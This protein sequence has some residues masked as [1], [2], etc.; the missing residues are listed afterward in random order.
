MNAIRY[1]NLFYILIFMILTTFGCAE[2]N[3]ITD[4]NKIIEQ[5]EPKEVVADVVSVEVTGEN[6]EY[7]FII[8]I[9]SPDLGCDQYAD[10]WEVLSEDGR[11]IYRRVL[12]HSHVNE[13][14]FVRSG[15]P[16]AITRDT[17]VIIRAHMNTTGYGGK[18][19]KGSISG[20]F[21]KI[22]LDPGFASE[23]EDQD[24]QPGDCAF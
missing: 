11:L 5:D 12:A 24:P 19:M 10:W 4:E 22:N 9:K 1:K 15:G 2:S 23:V 14:P 13:Q 16:V 17:I 7:Q 6:S 18:S 3:I 8:G 20:G 21:S